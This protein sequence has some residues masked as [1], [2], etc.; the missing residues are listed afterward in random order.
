MVVRVYSTNST[1]GTFSVRR[2]RSWYAAI[3]FRGT[4]LLWLCQCVANPMIEVCHSGVLC[5]SSVVGGAVDE[6]PLNSRVYIPSCHF[7]L[8]ITCG[9]CL[10]RRHNP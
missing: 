1:S 9:R 7:A 4:S 2:G 3:I 6:R 8:T 5:S 10:I